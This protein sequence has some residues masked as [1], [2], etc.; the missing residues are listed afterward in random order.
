MDKVTIEQAAIISA[1][2]GFLLGSFSAMHEYAEKKLGRPIWTHEFASEA[3][4]AELREAAMDD[5]VNLSPEA[6]R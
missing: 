6:T 2:T 4:T 1:Y 3:L 5:F